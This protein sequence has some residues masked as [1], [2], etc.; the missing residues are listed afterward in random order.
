M[1]SKLPEI[2]PR[3]GLGGSQERPEGLCEPSWPSSPL[4]KPSYSHLEPS[5]SPLGAILGLLGTLLGRSWALMGPSRS[6]FGTPLRPSSGHLRPSWGH[7]GPSWSLQGARTRNPENH[8]KT[9]GFST[10]LP[11]GT[12]SGSVL[13]GSV[14]VFGSS[15]G[16]QEASGAIVARLGSVSQDILAR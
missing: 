7:L 3:R 2:T 12:P 5:W 15:C 16:I 8:R 11:S 14:T 10:F 9:I 13:G 1:P 4:L 6:H